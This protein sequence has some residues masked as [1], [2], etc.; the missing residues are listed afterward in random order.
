MFRTC[1]SFG[2]KDNKTKFA[3]FLRKPNAPWE[4]TKIYIKH[5]SEIEIIQKEV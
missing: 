1:C 3:G 2:P 5:K 4:F